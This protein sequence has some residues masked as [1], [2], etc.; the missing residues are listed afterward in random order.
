MVSTC[1]KF[2]GMEFELIGTIG[3][4]S[5]DSSVLKRIKSTELNTYRIN[6]SHSSESLL[7]EYLSIFNENQI[8]PSLDT[9]GAQVRIIKIPENPIFSSGQ[10]FLLSTT[11]NFDRQNISCPQVVVNHPEIFDQIVVGDA[12]KIGFEGLVA[13]VTEV[14]VEQQTCLLEVVSPGKVELNKALDVS[15]KP[16]KLQPFT[17]FDISC[18]KKAHQ[19][20]VDTIFISFCDSAETVK[21]C[22]EIVTSS[23]AENYH[24]NPRIIAKIETRKALIALAEIIDEADGVLIDRGDLSREIRI[25]SIPSVVLSILN[26]CKTNNTPCFVA[27]NILDS[28][29]ESKLPS[30]AEISDIYNLLSQG[31]SGFV[32]AAEMAIGK[33]PV[34][35]V[36]ILSYMKKLY[37][38]EKR[39]LMMTV[40]ARDLEPDLPLYLQK[41]L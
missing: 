9:Q 37:D 19:F 17:S 30:R 16:I 10:H 14:S 22:R 21:Q 29:I 5:L 31:V 32:L 41:W 36:Q 15:N 34:E 35:S 13:I 3:P 23:I 2:E 39:T 33:H 20:D 1:G 4:A 12:I 11:D 18:L 6:L 38:L 28:M 8:K 24:F 27:T 7:K 40:S 26:T 25:S